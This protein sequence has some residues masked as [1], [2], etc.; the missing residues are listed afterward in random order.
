[1]DIT[2]VSGYSTDVNDAMKCQPQAKK[3]E[4][5]NQKTSDV[6]SIGALNLNFIII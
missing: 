4:K 3:K 5:E 1:M 6:W 2:W